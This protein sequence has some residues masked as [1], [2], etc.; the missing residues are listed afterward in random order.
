MWQSADAR[1]ETGIPHSAHALLHFPGRAGLFGAAQ[2]PSEDDRHFRIG[3]PTRLRLEHQTH[4]AVN[5]HFQAGVPRGRENQHLAR[6]EW[7]IAPW[8]KAIEQ[9]KAG[10]R[11]VGSRLR[12]R[13]DG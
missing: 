9:P 11:G 5:T 10:R 13:Y 2:S 3:M 1:S 4:I 12:S 6:K 8:Q 7:K